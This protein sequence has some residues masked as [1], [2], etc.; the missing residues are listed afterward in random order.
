MK[1]NAALSFPCSFTIKVIGYNQDSF[2]C[3]T[4]SIIQKHSKDIHQETIQIRK[5]KKEKYLSISITLEIETQNQLN[6]L[7]NDLNDCKEVIM[8]L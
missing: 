7:Y 2:E 4:L 8:T 5:S 1:K 3:A 6:T